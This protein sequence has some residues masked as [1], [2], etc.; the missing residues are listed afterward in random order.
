MP[1]KQ[2]SIPGLEVSL[3]PLTMSY[4]PRRK[5]SSWPA[6]RITFLEKRIASLEMELSILKIQME[7]GHA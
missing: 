7:L 6:D 2:L 1:D 5:P 3:G 4:T